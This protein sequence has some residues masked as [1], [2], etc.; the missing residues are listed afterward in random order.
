MKW[1]ERFGKREDDVPPELRDKTPEQIAEVLHKAKELEDAA[2]AAADA[3]AAAEAG[4][5]SLQTEL[6]AMKVKLAELEASRGQQPPEDTPPEPPSVWEDPA[7][8]VQDQTKGIASVALQAGVMA[9]KMYFSQNLSARDQKIFRKY[10]KEVEGVVATF[11]PEA[12]VMPQGWLNAFLYTKGLHDSEISKAESDKTD[13]FSESPS[14]NTT[15]DPEPTDTLTDEEKAVCKAMH[16]SE[17]GY[18]KR[19]KE[20]TILQSSKGAYARFPVATTTTR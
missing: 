18:L 8:F 17:E 7:K 5:A 10:E 3:K 1:G 14:R 12:R 13:F 16:W 9:A 6:D 20:Q 11:A 2:Q 19:K 4:A 15:P